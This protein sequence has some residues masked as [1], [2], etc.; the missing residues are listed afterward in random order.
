[1]KWLIYI[2]VLIGAIGI[3][4]GLVWALDVDAF[5]DDEED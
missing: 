5:E 1:M 2:L 3:G 4:F